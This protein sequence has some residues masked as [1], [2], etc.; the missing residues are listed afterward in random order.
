MSLSLCVKTS[1]SEN[2]LTARGQKTLQMSSEVLDDSRS[3][4][5][6]TECEQTQ[7]THTECDNGVC[8]VLL[9]C[10]CVQG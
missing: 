6:Q 4:K 1:E 9:M 7:H 5:N 3:L 2:S 10:L 8:D